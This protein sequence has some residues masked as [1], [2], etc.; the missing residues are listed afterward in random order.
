MF[1]GRASK[2]CDCCVRFLDVLNAPVEL[3]VRRNV[4]CMDDE[5]KDTFFIGYGISW[6]NLVGV[7]DLKMVSFYV[8]VLAVK[9]LHFIGMLWTILL[10]GASHD[11][12]EIARGKQSDRPA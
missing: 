3:L 12:I 10:K 2:P 1:E 4:T 11:H 7:L 9:K 5:Q 6:S 8:I